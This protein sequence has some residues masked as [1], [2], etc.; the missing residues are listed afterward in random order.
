MTMIKLMQIL[1]VLDVAKVEEHEV[2]PLLP[3]KR[4]DRKILRLSEEMGRSP[5]PAGEMKGPYDWIGLTRTVHSIAERLRQE[6]ERHEGPVEL[7]VAGRAPLPLFVQL[8][9]EMTKF[10]GETKVALLN[11]YRGGPWVAYPLGM[12]RAGGANVFFDEPNAL[13]RKNI[14]SGWVAVYVSTLGAPAPEQAFFDVL[15]SHGL[16]CADILEIRT[17]AAGDV[18]VEN[19]SAIA[20]ELV[21]EWPRI[22]DTYPNAAGLA[23]FVAGPIPVAFAVGR[24]I[25]FHASKDIWVMNYDRGGDNIAPGYEV[26]V[27]LPY[28]E[29]RAPARKDTPEDELARRKTLDTMI[30]GIEELRKTLRKGDFPAWDL[31]DQSNKY[32]KFLKDLRIPREPEEMGFGLSLVHRELKL[33][34]GLLDAARTATRTANDAEVLKRFAGLLLLHEMYHDDQDLRTTNFAEIGRAGMVLEEVDF[35]ADAFALETLIRWDIRQGGPRAKEKSAE[36]ACKWIDTAIFG[37]E[38]FDH[39]EPGA[40]IEQ[41]YE[42]RLRRYLIWHL[43]FERARTIRTSEDI[44]ALFGERIFVEL[45]PLEGTLDHR[46]DKLV[47][48]GILGRTE[49]FVVCKGRL[50]RR[51]PHQ[52]TRFEPSELVNAVRAFDRVKIRKMLEVVVNEHSSVLV[53]WRAS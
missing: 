53:P 16:A 39:F 27:S 26:A 51:A 7:Y 47:K 42:R 21:R 15:Q 14:A 44:G 35:W 4:Y 8:G 40:Q 13:G 52:P 1:V 2:L 19:A 11:P 33:G 50:V 43:Q 6:R 31:A 12:E 32:I 28:R 37:I 20:N 30:E 34:Q 17:K 45:A 9:H 49:I 46:Q 41:L 5:A 22:K 48:C 10:G 23:L 18:N 25:N 36:L 24:A 29:P 38:A 3:D